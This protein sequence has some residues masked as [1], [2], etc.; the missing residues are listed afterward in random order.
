MS[1]IE[2][3]LE[4]LELLGPGKDILDIEIAAKHS[5]VC[6]TLTYRYHGIHASW[7]A[8]AIKQQKLS[9]QQGKEL[10][11]YIKSLTERGL[12]PTQEMIQNFAL[13]ITHEHVGDGWVTCFISHQI[14]ILWEWRHSNPWRRNEAEGCSIEGA[15]ASGY[16]HKYAK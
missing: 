12:P 3:V 7:T 11:Q 15:L 8:K 6:F 4:D 13:Q 16:I 9:P 1:L 10:V 14:I 2:E 5:V